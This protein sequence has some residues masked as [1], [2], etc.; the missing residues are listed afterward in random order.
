M[1][2]FRLYL[3]FLAFVVS[4][5]SIYC[6]QN[7]QVGQNFENYFIFLKR[8]FDNPNSVGAIAPSSPQ[9]AAAMIKEMCREDHVFAPLSILEVGAG[10]GVF[11]QA[12][13]NHLRPEDHLDVIEIEPTFC[14]LLRE[15]IS[16]KANVDVHELSILDWK[17]LKKYDLIISGLPF[18]AF[19]SDM[20]DQILKHYTNLIAPSGRITFFEYSLLP[21]I[22]PLFLNKNKRDEYAKIRQLI[23]NFREQFEFDAQLVLIN[24][25]PAW[26][27][28]LEVPTLSEQP[29]TVEVA[30]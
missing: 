24:L 17:P 7:K 28:Y 8:F 3:F 18:N 13:I 10:T 11:T 1:K 9:L 22:K 30:A 23:K 6:L 27:Y 16:D 15:K 19:P 25:P 21:S 12:I 4:T 14:T 5:A 2:R 26:V 20:V 29:E